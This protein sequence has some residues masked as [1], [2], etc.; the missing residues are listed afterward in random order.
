MEGRKFFAFLF[1]ST[2]LG[3]AL[4]SFLPVDS[5]F[6]VV[7]FMAAYC[8]TALG[9]APLV[10]MLMMLFVPASAFLPVFAAAFISGFVNKRVKTTVLQYKRYD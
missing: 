10:A 4:A 3:F 1:C 2:A 6:V 9:L 5:S 7:I 8:S